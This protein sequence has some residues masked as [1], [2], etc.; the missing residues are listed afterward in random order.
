MGMVGGRLAHRFVF[1]DFD[2]GKVLLNHVSELWTICKNASYFLARGHEQL[3]ASQDHR[4][5]VRIGRLR[6]GLHQCTIE[7]PETMNRRSDPLDLIPTDSL[8]LPTTNMTNSDKHSSSIFVQN[9]PHC[10]SSASREMEQQGSPNIS[11]RHLGSC[12]V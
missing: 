4:V 12:D 8:Q 2:E 10:D 1:S 5:S 9:L 11:I 6:L 3:A 7:T